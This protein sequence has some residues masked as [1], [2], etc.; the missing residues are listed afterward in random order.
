MGN[1]V[2]NTVQLIQQNFQLGTAQGKASA[3]TW[4][5]LILFWILHFI[6]TTVK[7]GDTTEYFKIWMQF[8]PVELF[9]QFAI[10]PMFQEDGYNFHIPTTCHQQGWGT[11]KRTQ[12]SGVVKT[13]TF[14]TSERSFSETCLVYNSLADLVVGNDTVFC[15]FQIYSAKDQR[16]GDAMIHY[17]QA[18]DP[19]WFFGGNTPNGPNWYRAPGHTFNMIGIEGYSYSDEDDG[20]YN[21]IKYDHVFA[22]GHALKLPTR[23]YRSYGR[24]IWGPRNNKNAND[25]ELMQYWQ[26]QD[27]WM[28]QHGRAFDFWGWTAYMGG[29]GFL[30]VMLHSLIMTL[31]KIFYFGV[32][33]ENISQGQFQRYKK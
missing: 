7:Y 24:A 20:G 12:L 11:N 31:L 28:Y 1:V 32:E 4:V 17:S 25:T 26:T 22:H 10:C 21:Q 5:V 6:F 8:E 19:N 29:C 9:P 33:P 2:S 14:K 3:I 18:G 23:A 16:Y 13:F 15:Q 27:L 30:M